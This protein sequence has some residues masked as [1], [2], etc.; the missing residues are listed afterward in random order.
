MSAHLCLY[1]WPTSN[2]PPAF[3]ARHSSDKSTIDVLWCS[4]YRTVMQAPSPASTTMT[5]HGLS[6]ATPPGRRDGRKSL[7]SAAEYQLVTARLMH[8]GPSFS[9]EGCDKRVKLSN[10]VD[11]NQLQKSDDW[12]TRG[13]LPRFTEGQ[14]DRWSVSGE[15]RWRHRLAASAL[16]VRRSKRD[17][18]RWMRGWEERAR[19]GVSGKPRRSCCCWTGSEVAACSKWRHTTT[20]LIHSSAIAKYDLIL[21]DRQSDRQTDRQTSR[22]GG[23]LWKV[24]THSSRRA[25]RVSHIQTTDRDGTS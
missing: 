14:R 18:H 12:L 21:A 8:S 15:R 2:S 23:E 1:T 19:G 9:C 3:L 6:A 22:A 24:R 5:H 11:K 13:I 10:V 25:A 4:N 16:K 17:R 7:G 20:E